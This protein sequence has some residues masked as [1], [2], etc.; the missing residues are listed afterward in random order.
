MITTQIRVLDENNHIQQS[1]A[2]ELADIQMSRSTVSMS[3]EKG[4]TEFII[5]A[6]D[7]VALR[8]SCNAI[9]KQLVIYEK[10]TQIQ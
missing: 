9:C 8:A 4:V 3:H 6:K 1:F 7:A 2:S 5:Q 10:M